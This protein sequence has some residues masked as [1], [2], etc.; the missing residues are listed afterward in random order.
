MR[1]GFRQ[2]G[3][4]LK[5][6]IVTFLL[7]ALTFILIGLIFLTVEIVFQFYINPNPSVNVLRFKAMLESNPDFSVSKH[8]W[9]TTWEFRGQ[10]AASIS[11]PAALIA[12]L[13]SGASSTEADSNGLRVLRIRG[14]LRWLS[15]GLLLAL[16]ALVA[17]QMPLDGNDAITSIALFSSVGAIVYYLNVIIIRFDEHTLQ[18]RNWRGRTVKFQM[19]DLESYKDGF[20]GHVL[21]FSSG[22]KLVIGQLEYFASYADLIEALDRTLERNRSA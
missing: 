13:N 18:Y 22:R 16:I 19:A 20:W 21:K 10:I 4:G 17:L 2:F 11:V 14:G 1:P 9:R 5:R 12:L 8:M 6:F 15:N 3:M 7:V